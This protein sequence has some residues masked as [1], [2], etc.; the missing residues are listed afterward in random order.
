MSRTSELE[1]V[2]PAPSLIMK[3]DAISVSRLAWPWLYHPAHFAQTVSI[4]IPAN[5]SHQTCFAVCTKSY[6]QIG[7]IRSRRSGASVLTVFEEI[8]EVAA[9]NCTA[10]GR[11]RLATTSRYRKRFA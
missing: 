6:T 2:C 3:A 7:V 8:V 5:R 9:L 4:R 10:A 1:A 11:V